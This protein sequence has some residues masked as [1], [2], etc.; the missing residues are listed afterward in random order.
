MRLSPREHVLILMMH[1]I[2]CDWASEGIIWRE[3]STLYQLISQ[4]K[5]QSS[6]PPCRSRTGITRSGSSRGLPQ[7]SFAED[8]AYWEETLRGRS[9]APRVA[10]GS[11]ATA[12]DVLSGTTPA[13][14]AK[15]RL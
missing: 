12:N 7:T 1:H 8:L 15:Q 3:L 9:G 6:C 13:L 10:R 5:A 2:I 11:G 4:R 14:E